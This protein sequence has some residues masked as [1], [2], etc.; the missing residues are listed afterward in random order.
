M[1]GRMA[2]RAELISTVEF[3]REAERI[4]VPTL[5]VTGEPGLDHVVAPHTTSAYVALI[6]G[7][8]GV[9]LERTGHLG[10]VTRP[11]RFA[12]LVN[13]FALSIRHDHAA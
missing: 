1:L 2:K 3:A 7:A 5:V 9:T 13:E 6:R 12:A 4:A 11:E 10:S 8:Q